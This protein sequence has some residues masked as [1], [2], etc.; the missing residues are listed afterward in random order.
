[1]V[2]EELGLSL[3]KTHQRYPGGG[4]GGDP[5]EEKSLQEGVPSAVASWFSV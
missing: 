5:K 4:M 1:M 3:R 2:P